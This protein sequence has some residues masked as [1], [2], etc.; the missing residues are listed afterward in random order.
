[1]HCRRKTR[2]TSLCY[3]LQ[4]A[5]FRRTVAGETMEGLA[6]VSGILSQEGSHDERV[7][8]EVDET[9]CATHIDDDRT[10]AYFGLRRKV[11]SAEM[12][13]IIASK[14]GNSSK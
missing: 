8:K 14:K 4:M 7:V 11:E 2:K 1:M 12:S 6:T 9:L 13:G 5:A 10:R 3:R